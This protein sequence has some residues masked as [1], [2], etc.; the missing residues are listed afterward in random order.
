MLIEEAL[1]KNNPLIHLD[2]TGTTR[3]DGILC[4]LGRKLEAFFQHREGNDF[5]LTPIAP[6]LD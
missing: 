5:R 6:D 4:A 1:K 3:R 2:L